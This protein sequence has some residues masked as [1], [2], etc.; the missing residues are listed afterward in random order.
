MAYVIRSAR[1]Y[2]KHL[3]LYSNPVALEELNDCVYTCGYG[4]IWLNL[5]NIATRVDEIRSWGYVT[6]HNSYSY[7]SVLWIIYMMRLFITS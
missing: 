6:Y 2:H 3:E 5:H 4:I 1:L 7:W